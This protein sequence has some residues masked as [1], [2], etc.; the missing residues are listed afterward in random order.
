MTDDTQCFHCGAKMVEYRFGL[1][2]GLLGFLKALV[3]AAGPVSISSLHLTNSEYSNYPKARYWGLTEQVDP[4]NEVEESKGGKWQLTDNGML[5]LRRRLAIPKYV[6]TYRGYVRRFEGD[7]IFVDGIEDGYQY[8]G[9]YR[10]Q[11]TDQMQCHN[12][13]NLL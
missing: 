13:L 10:S 3:A 1:N 6:V 8:R 9:D 11:V 2:T 5:F 12:Q 7:S 4:Q